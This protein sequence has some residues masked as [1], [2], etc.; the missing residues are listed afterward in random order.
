LVSGGT[1]MTVDVFVRD[2]KAGMTA[3]V[4]AG[5]NGRQSNGS[6]FG[7]PVISDDGR[8][9]AF[10][11]DATNLVSGD[12]NGVRDIFVHDRKAGASA[13]ISVGPKVQEGD[14]PSSSASISALGRSVAF[15]SAAGNLVPG[16][17][18]GQ[19]DVFVRAR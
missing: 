13:R 4:S 16:D 11:S 7:F 10:N 12:T 19:G 9:V 17:T 18:N 1:N 8:T 15:A 5:P 6:S 2:H 3:R 14:G